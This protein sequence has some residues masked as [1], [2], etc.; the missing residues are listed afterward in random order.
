MSMLLV[1]VAKADEL[2]SLRAD[3][4]QAEAVKWNINSTPYKNKLKQFDGYPLQDY[5][6][7]AQLKKNL[8]MKNEPQISEFLNLYNSTPLD[9]SLRK[10]WLSHLIRYKYKA[11]FIKYYKPSS[12]KQFTCNYYQFQLDTGVNKGTVL[13]NITELWLT[14]ESL[15]KECDRLFSLWTKK[16]YR[17]NELIWQRVMLAQKN[18]KYGLVKY[19]LKLLPQKEQYLVELWK[20][21]KRSSKQ[22]VQLQKFKRNNEQETL[23]IVYGLKRLIWKDEVLALSVFEKADKQGRF[24]REQKESILNT[25]V[26]AVARSDDPKAQLW[27][28][29]LEREYIHSGAIQWRVAALLRNGNYSDLTTE[30]KQLNEEQQADRQWLYWLARAFEKTKQTDKAQQIYKQLATIRSYYGFLAAA[31]IGDKSLLNHQPINI[32]G[33]L[34]DSISSVKAGQRAMELYRLNRLTEA[35]REWNFWMTQLDETEQMLAAKWAH[36]QGWYDRGIYSLSQIGSLNDMDVRFPMPFQNEFS[37]AA[38]R[39][40]VNEAWAYAIAR[41]ESIFMS[42]ATSSVGALGLMQVKPITANYINKSKLKRWQILDPDTNIE[43]GIKYLSYLQKK[44]NN[45]IV[46]ATVAYNAGPKKV[47]RWLKAEPSLP[48]DAWIETIPYK[49][50]RE[51][52]KSVLAFT[53]IYQQKQ[54]SGESPF[55]ELIDMEIE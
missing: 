21:I 9:W 39:H 40:N 2:D 4:L 51:Y 35:R 16:G 14:G 45:N 27:F 42:D 43:L 52:V 29:N 18:R 24:N 17:T 53:E 37:K 36:Q 47:Y 13:P 33:H 38:K 32:P 54:G 41:K 7:L 11:R 49:E 30:L 23:V 12:N 34:N 48:V 25:L 50:T 46:L 3:F 28:A 31:K 20:K 44:F 5:F 26:T 55:I 15:P 8:L 19:L 6:Q 10:L 1:V 22:V